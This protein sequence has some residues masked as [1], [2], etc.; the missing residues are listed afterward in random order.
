MDPLYLIIQRLIGVI[1]GILLLVVSFKLFYGL[2]NK[3][4][5]LSMIFLH[6]ERIINLFRVLILS[7]IFT[8]LTGI[9]YVFFGNSIIVEI[10]LDLNALT[11][12]IFTFSF[13]KVMGGDGKWT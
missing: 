6:E 8:V 5:A 3:D 10:L 1:L 12:L 2:K 11:L 13:Q 7:G 9:V 4:V